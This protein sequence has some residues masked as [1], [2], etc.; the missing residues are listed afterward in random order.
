[1]KKKLIVHIGLHKTGTSSIQGFLAAN[2][3]TFSA[4][5]VFVPYSSLHSNPHAGLHHYIAGAFKE[6]KPGNINYVVNTILEE[7]GNCPTVLL[8]SEVLCEITSGISSVR[9]VLFSFFDPV[10]V[11]VYLRRQDHTALS[12]YNQIVKRKGHS[13]RFDP[14]NNIYY[15]GNYLQLLQK[16]EREF[17]KEQLKVLVFEKKGFYKGGLLSDFLFNTLGIENTD[18]FVLSLKEVNKGW[19]ADAVEFCRI[20]NS[21]IPDAL[22]TGIVDAIDNYCLLDS[23]LDFPLESLFSPFDRLKYIKR[24]EAG[25][26]EIALNYLGRYDGTLFNE[27]LPDPNQPWIPFPGLNTVSA[28]KILKFIRDNFREV[29]DILVDDLSYTAITSANNIQSDCITRTIQGMVNKYPPVTISKLQKPVFIF[30][31][32]Q[33]KTGTTAIQQFLCANR[34]LLFNEHS[35]LYPDFNV[36]GFIDG[37]MENHAPV[38]IEALKNKQ[39]PELVNDFVRCYTFCE[40]KGIRKIIISNEGFFWKWWPR[41]LKDIIDKTQARCQ[42]IVYLRRQDHWIEAAWKQWGSKM[43]EYA[44]IYDYIDKKDLNWFDVLEHWSSFFDKRAFIVRPF[45]KT[46]TGSD[47]VLD[48]CQLTGLQEV[49]S[50]WLKNGNNPTSN[51]GFNND[52]VE[53]L[54]LSKQL[55][56]GQNDHHLI[57]FFDKQLSDNL[58]RKSKDHYNLLSP[59]KRLEILQQFEPSN[60]KI[61]RKYL[62]RPNGVLFDEPLPDQEEHWEQYKGITV[63]AFI[64]VVM[65]V[66][67]KQHS[68]INEMK[69]NLKTKV[70]L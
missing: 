12:A 2:R 41:V 53:W 60:R 1:V 4:H 48:F 30:H 13:G 25:N 63:E 31:I 58:K 55:V 42:I 33:P 34:K 54:R 26:K 36:P 52:I 11:I 37:K 51:V 39:I 43:H 3:A 46:Q 21:M 17:G 24:F 15:N 10:E 59:Q 66:L 8:S 44:G 69:K 47:V 38:F 9:D 56:K 70:S 7:S 68:E 49:Y 16:W 67:L 61:A 14:F 6:G 45:T 20:V 23:T 18:D 50:G 28:G 64:P 40:E 22:S 27:P 62:G 32:G 65:E 35:F 29:F 5:G 57:E 19:S